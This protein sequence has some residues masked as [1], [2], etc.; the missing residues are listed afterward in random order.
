[1]SGF[2]WIH[3]EHPS[4]KEGDTRQ[5][6]RFLLL[7]TRIGDETRWLGRVYITQRREKGF[8]TAGPEGP[9]FICLKWRNVRFDSPHEPFQS[10]FQSAWGVL[11][12]SA[13]L[14]FMIGISL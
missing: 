13:F 8:C 10:P 2:R 9:A 14:G 11:L 6:R 3:K 1:M 4:Y 5:V 12:S 7:P